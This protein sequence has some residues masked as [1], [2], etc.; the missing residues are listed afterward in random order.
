MKTNLLF[1]L[2]LVFSL[3]LF[4]V[5]LLPAPTDFAA[6]IVGDVIQT[7]W[8]AVPEAAKYSVNVVCEYDTDADGTADMSWDFD[9][10]TG[11]RTDGLDMS[12]P[13]LEIPLADLVLGVDTDFDEIPDTFYEPLS[14]QARVKALAPGKGKGRQDNLF[15]E[16]VGVF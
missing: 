7:S 9:F 6:P 1:L 15:S 10:G 4:A 8:T 3:P 5:G 13:S 2:P 14:A 16:F 11:D 12:E